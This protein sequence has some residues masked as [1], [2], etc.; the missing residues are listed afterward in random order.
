MKRSLKKFLDAYGIFGMCILVSIALHLAVLIGFGSYKLFRY[1]FPVDGQ[2]DAVPYQKKSVKLRTI[3]HRVSLRRK[4][5]KQAKIIRRIAVNRLTRVSLPSV[6]RREKLKRTFEVSR[7]FLEGSD[8]FGSFEDLSLDN[9]ALFGSVKKLDNAFAGTI[10]ARDEGDNSLG[11]TTRRPLGRR[12]SI[13]TK[14]LNVPTTHFEQGFPG[15]TERFE[16]FT[17]VYTARFYVRTP[18]EYTFIGSADDGIV[19]YIDGRKILQGICTSAEGTKKL[20]TG[21]HRIKVI[22]HQGPRYAVSL[23]LQVIPP[24][25][26]APRIFDLNDFLPPAGN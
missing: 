23:K 19:V 16:W 14:R 5:P 3:S 6:P 8:G 24:G 7:D 2:F 1:Y 10:Y 13:F 11:L 20:D 12:E 26:N 17:I 9:D 15:V 25:D 21:S 4:P 18:G 22:Y